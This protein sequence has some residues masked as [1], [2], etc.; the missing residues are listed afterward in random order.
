MTD[1]RVSTMPAGGGP[2]AGGAGATGA[3]VLEVTDL[4]KSFPVRSGD[5][6]PRWRIGRMSSL[7]DRSS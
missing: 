4:V 7:T 1:S 2:G 5:P 6:G 3:P